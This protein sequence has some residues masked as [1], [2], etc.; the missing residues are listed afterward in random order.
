MHAGD[1]MAGIDGPRGRDRR[2]DST[3]HRRKNLHH[4]QPT[5]RRH[6]T[7]RLARSTPPARS[8]RARRRRRRRSRYGRGENRNAPRAALVRPHRQQHVLGRATP[9]VQAE[10]VEHSMPRRRAA[11]AT[12]RLRSRGT[13]EMRVARQPRRQAATPGRRSAPHPG[14]RRAPAVSSPRAARP[15]RPHAL[16]CDV[17]ASCDRGGEAGDGRR[18][19]ACPTARRAPARR[20]A[21]PARPSVSRPS[22]NAPTPIGPPTLCPVIVSASSAAGAR[23]RPAAVRR[24]ARRRCARECRSCARLGDDLG[25]RL[26]G[27]DLVVRPHDLTR[28]TSSGS[29]SIAAAQRFGVH[30]AQ[31]V[32]VQP[33]DSAPSWL[34]E[35]L[36]TS[37]TA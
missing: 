3:G 14:P 8:R 12:R 33:A 24:P 7:G 34:G 15:A 11:S 6:D 4:L 10:P 16:G 19:R 1:V 36:D 17:T 23:S 32:D 31:V 26:H 30:P 20:R 35:P 21:A 13:A 37:S 2:I 9:A 25:D 28:A 29:A 18:R 5:R 27:A 22:S